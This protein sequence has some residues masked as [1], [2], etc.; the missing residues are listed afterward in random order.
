ML[1]GGQ[2]GLRLVRRLG[3]LLKLAAN[4]DVRP[5]LACICLPCFHCCASSGELQEG[6]RFSFAG[7][8][9]GM[10]YPVETSSPGTLTPGFEASWSD[11][12]LSNIAQCDH[13]EAP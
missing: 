1:L 6:S 5:T 3:P 13:G 11:R 8:I 12:S 7:G 10:N 4:R 2:Q 9:D